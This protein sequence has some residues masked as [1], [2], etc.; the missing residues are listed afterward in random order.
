VPAAPRLPGLSPEQASLVTAWLPHA[1][2]VRDHSW[3][4]TDTTVL[5]LRRSEGEDVVVK[6]AGPG[7]HHL[8]REVTAHE[9]WLRPWTSRGRA[10]TLLH[11]DRSAKVLVTAYLPG[12]LVEGD[13]SE[14]SPDTYRQAGRLLRLLHEQASRTDDGF[15]AAMDAR[16]LAW[17]DAPH[18]IDGTT[19]RELR[20]RI[21]DH[22]PGPARLVPTHGDWQPRNW[23]VHQGEVAA[24]DFGRAAW[25]TPDTDLARLSAQQFVGRPDLEAAFV[26]GY[27]SDPR[28]GEG[29]LRVLLREAVGTAVWA[30]QV[31]DESFEAQGHRMIRDVLAGC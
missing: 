14:G 15:E 29:W 23:L 12:R 21:D 22:R 20:R 18:R 10:P 28:S 5:Q 2:L 1:T 4:L 27:G 19:E 17:L 24:I 31:G 8:D 6:A 9:S 30:H 26:E 13:E 25:R 3:G 7:N 11:V 16:A